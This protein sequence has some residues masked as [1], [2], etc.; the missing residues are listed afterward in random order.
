MKKIIAKDYRPRFFSQVC[1]FA[2]G[3]ADVLMDW[4]AVTANCASYA[5]WKSQRS[6][7][8]KD[9]QGNAIGGATVIIAGTSIGTTTNEKGEFIIEAAPSDALMINFIGYLPQ[10]ISVGS[11]N[12]F[13]IVLEESTTS[14]DEV[15]VVG[16]GVRKKTTLTGSVVSVKGDEIAKSPAID[17]TAALAGRLPGLNCKYPCR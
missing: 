2:T 12:H 7:I 9:V 11:Q 8:V 5:G 17:V 10:N 14:I 1:L 4:L 15:M 6:G 16:Y 3:F 13:D